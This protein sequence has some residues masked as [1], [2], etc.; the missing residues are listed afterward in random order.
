M[1][2]YAALSQADKDILEPWERNFRGWVNG[3]I[4]RGVVEARAL[5]ASLDAGGGAGAILDSLDPG[6]IV[7]NTGGISGAQNLTK[8]EWAT[9]RTA[10]N[11][12]LTTYDTLS[13]REHAAKAAGPLAGL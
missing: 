12:F 4:S 13:V 2:T 10:F 7:P 1:G 9:L 8:E 5:K 6:E 11:T 3:H